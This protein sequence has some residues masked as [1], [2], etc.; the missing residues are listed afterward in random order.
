[1]LHLLRTSVLW[2]IDYLIT[3]DLE[4]LMESVAGLE[5]KS[6]P[7]VA[8]I[9]ALY[10]AE[11]AAEHAAQASDD[12]Q[13]A[14]KRAQISGAFDDTQSMGPSNDVAPVSKPLEKASET[15][16][17]KDVEQMSREVPNNSPRL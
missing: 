5:S 9:E 8:V 1:M 4:D 10:K 15:N 11:Q 13:A 16:D 12:L 7:A 14:V 6:E 17:R 2:I 3:T